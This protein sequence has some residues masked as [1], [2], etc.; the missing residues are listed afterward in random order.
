MG[1]TYAGIGRRVLLD[2]DSMPSETA[3]RAHG[4]NDGRTVRGTRHSISGL[5]VQPRPHTPRNQEP[6]ALR[7][8]DRSPDDAT[9]QRW[10]AQYPHHGLGILCGTP[11]ESIGDADFTGQF[12]IAVDIH[13]DDLVEPVRHALRIGPRALR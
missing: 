1:S 2:L 10:L 7:L 4:H 12:L 13:Q 9:F 3:E 11:L 5:R 8:A 6:R